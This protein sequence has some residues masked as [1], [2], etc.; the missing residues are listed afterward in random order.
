MPR[1]VGPVLAEAIIQTGCT[2]LSSPCWAFCSNLWDF[3]FINN[4]VHGKMRAMET[5]EHSTE[6]TAKL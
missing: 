6:H 1:F 4:S 2:S 3:Y 5:G